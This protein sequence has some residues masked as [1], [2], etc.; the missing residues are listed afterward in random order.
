M[1][2]VG[3]RP[4][5]TTFGA[6]LVLSVAVQVGGSVVGGF[7][8]AVNNLGFSRFPNIYTGDYLNSDGSITVYFGPG[9]PSSLMAA[10]N[11]IP[12]GGV[13]GIIGGKR[14]PISWVRVPASIATL[15]SLSEALRTHI[16][17]YQRDGFEVASWGPNPTTGTVDISLVNTPPGG[18]A[19]ATNY[20]QERLS[21][22]AR[23]TGVGNG[24]PKH[25]ANRGT[26]S[27][28]LLC[29]RETWYHC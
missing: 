2:K 17:S 1:Q 11:A 28:S 15:N 9:D 29:Q 20:F 25:F 3:R 21:P 7:G 6:L 23:V 22:L 4:A 14:P 27:R 26:G 19:R 16:T 12:L 18:A 5:I 24:V 10:I 13:A 8:D